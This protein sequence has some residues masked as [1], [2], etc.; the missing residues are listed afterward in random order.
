MRSNRDCLHHG[1]NTECLLL[2][3]SQLYVVCFYCLLY[4][5]FWLLFCNIFWVKLFDFLVMEIYSIQ[6]QGD[7]VIKRE[8]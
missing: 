5:S 2:H 6:A 1:I 8:L 7:F 3:L 4:A